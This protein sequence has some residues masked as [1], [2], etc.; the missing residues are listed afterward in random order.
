MGRSEGMKKKPIRVTFT[1]SEGKTVSFSEKTPLRDLVKA[2]I[3]INLVPKGTK[4]TITK[5][6]HSP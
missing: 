6:I 5:F 3:K 4:P 2:G 1:N